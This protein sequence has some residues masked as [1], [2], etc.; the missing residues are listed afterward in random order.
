MLILTVLYAFVVGQV[1]VIPSV[2]DVGFFAY[3]SGS[4][5]TSTNKIIPF[6]SVA[7][8]DG[9]GYN[10]STST[11]TAPVAGMYQFYWSLLVQSSSGF[12]LSLVQNGTEKIRQY[13]KNTS[14]W[15]SSNSGR[16]IYLRLKRGDI[17]YLKADRPGG[18]IVGGTQNS[19]GGELI[20]Y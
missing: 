6:Q 3:R 11:F 1:N 5:T 18:N 19:F 7:R 4:F 20:R 15:D 2:T 17:L 9:Q 14:G 10:T 13:Y 8:N 12:D 16:S